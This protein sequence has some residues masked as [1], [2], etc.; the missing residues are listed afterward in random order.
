MAYQPPPL[1]LRVRLRNPADKPDATTGRYGQLENQPDW[2]FDVW[3]ARSDRSSRT[4]V[5]ETA[6]IEEQST[7]W[8]IRERANVAADVEIVYKGQVFEAIGQPRIRGGAGQGRAARY[9]EIRTR[10]RQ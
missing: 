2:G 7:V 9:F 8:T 5:E 4:I 6:A 3:A 1:T 10:M